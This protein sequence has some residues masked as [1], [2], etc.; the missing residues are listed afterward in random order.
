M[1]TVISR[2]IRGMAWLIFWCMGVGLVQLARVLYGRILKCGRGMVR[3]L[4]KL[5]PSL[6]PLIIV[7]M[8]SILPMTACVMAYLKRRSCSMK[9]PSTTIR[10]FLPVVMRKMTAIFMPTSVNLQPFVSFISICGKGGWNRPT[11]VY[12]GSIK[13]IPIRL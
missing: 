13:L 7:I 12:N 2:I 10:F 4:P 1:R 9:T 6:I 11:A 3:P 8:C 5:T